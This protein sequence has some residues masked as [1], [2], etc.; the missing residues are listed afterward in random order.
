[1]FFVF[2]ATITHPYTVKQC[3][4]AHARKLKRWE[5][6]DETRAYLRH[7]RRQHFITA[8]YRVA[9]GKLH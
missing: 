5:I 1:M 6:S 8:G 4:L 2:L 7:R 9:R 3:Q